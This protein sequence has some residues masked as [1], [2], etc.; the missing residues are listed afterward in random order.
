MDFNNFIVIG[1]NKHDND[2]LFKLAEDHH[3]WFH[4]AN[5]SSAHLWFC[6]SVDKI[7]KQNLY[8]IALVLKQKSK[9]AKVNSI[10]IV[11]AQKSQ[12]QTSD[13][14]GQIIVIGKHKTIRV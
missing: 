9:F 8:K 5:E 10:E 11:Y 7:A 13:I 4:I 14:P 3:T 1:K 6:E 2:R 12:L